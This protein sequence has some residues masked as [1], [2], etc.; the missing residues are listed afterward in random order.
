MVLRSEKKKS[1]NI[2][3]INVIHFHLY[4]AS[5]VS[6]NTI[7]QVYFPDSQ[8]SEFIYTYY[9]FINHFYEFVDCVV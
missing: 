6:T 9:L 2:Q 5:N 4:S 3:S 8:N 7:K 1:F